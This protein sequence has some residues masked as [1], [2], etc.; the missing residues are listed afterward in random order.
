MV[1]LMG[2][3][4]TG[5]ANAVTSGP[6]A[7]WTT[8][9]STGSDTGLPLQR[10]FARTSWATALPSAGEVATALTV[11]PYDESPWDDDTTTGG[12][13]NHIEGW[14]GTNSLHNV[15]HGWVGGSMLPSTS[16]NDP[17]FFLHHCFVDKVWAD[18][19]AANPGMDYVPATAQARPGRSAAHGRNDDV[20][21]FDVTGSSPV[22]FKPSESLDI[23]NLKD[24]KGNSGIRVRYL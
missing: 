15:V 16:P 5:S 17:C 20:P 8:F 12:F 13:R 22:T 18:W 14:F 3:N 24:H 4:G 10:S 2:G 7:G 19:Q 1:S 11:T 6:F 23:G 9:N 21:V